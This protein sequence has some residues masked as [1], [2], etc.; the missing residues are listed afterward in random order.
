MV[1][2]RALKLEV[3]VGVP[4]P[5]L[6][7]LVEGVG[8]ELFGRS[9]EADMS[10]GGA[11]DGEKREGRVPARARRPEDGAAE[12]V[13]GT[14]LLKSGKLR[15]SLLGDSGIVSRNGVELPLVGGPHICGF[16][17]S[18]AWI[19]RALWHVLVR[20]VPCLRV[21]QTV[22]KIVYRHIHAMGSQ[23]PAWCWRQRRRAGS[24]CFPRSGGS[25]CWAARRATCCQSTRSPSAGAGAAGGCS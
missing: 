21:R 19:S 25:R 14:V 2:P 13:S 11:A 15:L 16:K 24:T 9:E 8:R 20:V 12:A 17:P 10:P 5:G 22:W 1:D 6:K 18:C 3:S 4:G 7:G 23:H